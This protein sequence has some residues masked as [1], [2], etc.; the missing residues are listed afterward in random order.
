[1]LEGC[2][3]LDQTVHN[4]QPANVQEIGD[5]ITEE[6]AIGVDIAVFLEQMVERLQLRKGL[7]DP[8]VWPVLP[9]CISMSFCHVFHRQY[10]SLV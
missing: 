3:V 2:W 4:K 8:E 7:G 10:N 5:N 6:Y 1:M 9:E